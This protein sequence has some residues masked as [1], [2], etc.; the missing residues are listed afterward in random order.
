M[1]GSV[2]SVLVSDVGVEYRHGELVW[3][4]RVETWLLPWSS[5]DSSVWIRCWWSVSTAG[6]GCSGMHRLSVSRQLATDAVVRTA[7]Q[8]H[9][10]W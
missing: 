1:N 5:M 2:V 4:A 9:D 10:S 3:I 8:C 7:S 6:N